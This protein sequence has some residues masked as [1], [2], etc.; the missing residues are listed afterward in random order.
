S[1]L[2]GKHN[3]FHVKELDFSGLDTLLREQ[4]SDIVYFGQRLAVGSN[5]FALEQRQAGRTMDAFTDT[6]DE[7]AQRSA[8]LLSPVYFIALAGALDDELKRSLHASVLY[9]ESED[10]YLHHH[11]V[12]VWAQSLDAELKQTR[13]TYGSLVAEHEASMRW[14]KGLDVELTESARRYGALQ[15]DYQ[16]AI[17]DRDSTIASLRQRQQKLAARAEL[18]AGELAALQNL[19]ALV[20]GSRSW[21]LTRPLRFAMRV[22]RGEWG[23]ARGGRG[24]GFRGARVVERTANPHYLGSLIDSMRGVLPEPDAGVSV[25]RLVL[26]RFHQPRVTILIPAYGQL[27]VTAAC[28]RSIA[29]N[30]PQVPFEVLVVEDAS[31]DKAMRQLAGVSGLRYEVNAENLGFL[32][33]C[34][35]AADLARGEFIHLLNNDTEVTDGWLDAMLTVFE[36]FPDCGLVG[37]KL[38]YPDGRLQEAGGIVWKDGTAWNYGRLDDPS[39]S[40]YNYVREADYCSGAS[41]LIRRNLFEKLGRFDER[42][43]PAYCEDSDLAFKVREAG[44]K[45]YYQPQSVV[46]HKE[47]VSHGTDETAGIKA[48]QPVNQKKFRDRWREVLARENYASGEDVFRA[49][50]RTRGVPTVLMVDHYTPQPDRDA[51][52]RT[53]WQFM[54]RFL[55]HGWSVKFW[56]ENLCFDPVYAPRMQQAGIEVV[57]GFEYAGK[58]ADWMREFGHELDVVL[59]S[60][61]HVAA[62]FLDAVRKRSRARVLYYG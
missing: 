60:R 10:L 54:Q 4:F 16:A 39:R 1:K 51:G 24:G 50:G 27:P 19:H 36:R 26:P 49:R 18:L 34:N 37:S 2:S 15:R 30:P 9:S 56:P 17:A 28:L 55:E 6:G 25:E 44:L 61:P 38:V 20:I 52:S 21:R 62:N 13:E 43:L 11:E 3:E 23:A 58:F 53:M 47:G 7:V 48:H 22:L 29:E 45:V 40:I 5:I 32:R 31:G 57:Y 42:Y 33:S 8:S 14:A 59:L 12:A 41:L 35:R 46:V